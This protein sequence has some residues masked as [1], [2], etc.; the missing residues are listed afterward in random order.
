MKY[1]LSEHAR[2]AI[3]KRGILLEWLEEAL[4]SPEYSEPDRLDPELEHRLLRVADSGGRVL[5]VIVNVKCAE[6]R[7]VTAYFDRGRKK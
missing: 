2:G 4:V 3:A 5:R 7:V 1:V 6:L